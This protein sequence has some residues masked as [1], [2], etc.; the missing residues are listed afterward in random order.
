MEFQNL[1]NL[2]DVKDQLTTHPNRTYSSHR[3]EEI[4]YI[5]IHHSA[6]PSGNAESFANYHVNN[7]NWPG[8][9]YHFV[10]LRNGDVQWTNRLEVT[11]FH[12]GGH[13][14]GNIGICL[15]GDGEFTDIQIDRVVEL[16]AALRED[17]YVPVR[18]VLGHNE[19]PEQSTACP[20]LDMDMLRGRIDSIDGREEEPGGNGGEDMN[21]PTQTLRRG[22][23]GEQV[24]RL[25]ESL[26]EAGQSLPRYGADGIFGSETE[27]GVLEFQR[28]HGLAVDGIAGPETLQKLREVLTK[29]SDVIHR[30]Q[31]GAFTDRDNAEELARE[32]REQGY[33]VYIR[34]S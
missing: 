11:S 5:T 31:V 29:A 8:I 26:M 6:T 12:T 24:R 16:V 32:L 10:I 34:T 17:L 20:S 22:D 23:R 27:N 18:R 15:V 28:K 9:G 2:E 4:S 21:L 30:V 3:I 33:D 13:N 1:A 14:T 19:H 7:N 25:Q